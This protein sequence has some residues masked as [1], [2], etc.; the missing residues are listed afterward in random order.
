LTFETS[1]SGSLPRV[2]IEFANGNKASVIFADL[3][4]KLA[5]LPPGGD[6][7]LGHQ[8]ASPEELVRFLVEAM[9]GFNLDAALN[10]FRADPADSDYQRGFLAAI[11]QVFDVA[12][13]ELEAQC[14]A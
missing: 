4:C 5:L 11:L 9:S 12:D 1:T 6:V 10:G 3:C 13:A 8:E 2:H 14:K 7:R